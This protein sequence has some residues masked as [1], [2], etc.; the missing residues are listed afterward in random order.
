MASSVA[1]EMP[2]QLTPGRRNTRVPA[3][4]ATIVRVS[5]FKT[6][7]FAMFHPKPA[8]G[9][10]YFR[11][12]LLTICCWLLLLLRLLLLLLQLLLLLLLLLLPLPLLLLL[13]LLPLLHFVTATV[14]ASVP[15]QLASPLPLLLLP[16]LL[17]LLLLRVMRER[18]I[19]ICPEQGRYHNS[20]S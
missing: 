2:E 20:R 6:P 8:R 4:S 16:L 19:Y 15:L 9:L 12:Q 14:T 7:A 5:G 3:R 17:P 13:L 18:D 1:M 11:H 10:T